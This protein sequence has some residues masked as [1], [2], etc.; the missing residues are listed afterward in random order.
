MKRSLFCLVLCISLL[1]V[2]LTGC[3][4]QQSVEVPAAQSQPPAPVVKSE[5][6]PQ[7][8]PVS[9]ETGDYGLTAA[10]LYDSRQSSPYWQDIYDL[11]EQSVLIGLRVEAVDVAGAYDLSA[12]DLV[13]PEGALVDS[14]AMEQLRDD[15]MSYTEQGGYVL[16]DNR[17]HACMPMQY[18]GV[19]QITILDGC[20]LDMTYPEVGADLGGLQE[21]IRDLASLYGEYYEAE[22]LLAMDYGRGF[23]T[24]TAI[25]LADWNGQSVYTFH[26]YGSGAVMLTNPLLPNVYS[27]GNLSMTHRSEAETAFSNTTASCN[28]LLY[29][30]FAG[31]VAK[32]K[33]GYALN[34]VYG[35]H[36][37]PSMA[38]ELHYEES[39]RSRTIP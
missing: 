38:W 26:N 30:R 25:S 10:V 15:L 24:D 17:F 12:Y 39:L 32:E 21:V 5:P 29:S 11:L 18:L 6:L 31:L 4:H 36:G 35:S 13:I 34:R 33:F 8:E 16:L 22:A 9:E 37:S 2:C 1:C 27:L 7:A 14:A 28:Q 19:S 23:V 3:G 20:P